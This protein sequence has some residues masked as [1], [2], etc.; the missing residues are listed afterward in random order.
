M[1]DS[2]TVIVVPLDGSKNAENAIPAAASLQ[3]L[4]GCEIRLVHV[5]E[6]R[7]KTP[8]DLERARATFV[9]YAEEAAT[10]LGAGTRTAELLVDSSPARAI[11][12]NASDARFIVIATHGR[13]GFKATILGSVA[14]KVVRGSRVPVLVVPGVG[15]PAAAFATRSIMVAL[16][17]S[18]A[19]EAGLE[20][21]R[22]IARRAE[23]GIV[24]ARAYRVSV[25]VGIEFSYYPIDMI[26]GYEAETQAYLQSM[27]R[28]GERQLVLQGLPAEAI[29]DAAGQIGADM[30]VMATEGKGL[31]GRLAL[32]STTDRVMHSLHRPLLVV[33]AG[34]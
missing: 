29:V 3:A 9:E 28:D 30:V 33:P 25:P 5:A 1:V 27:A 15:T 26:E 10:R 22:D 23:A 4:Y 32:G 21:A 19:A 13:S 6:N 11:L 18:D 34:D 24:L 8:Q 12:D 17:G 7:P 16:D 2:G 14:D 20:V 31:A